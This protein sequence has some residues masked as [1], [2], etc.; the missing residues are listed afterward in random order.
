M[1]LKDNEQ[2]VGRPGLAGT[3]TRSLLSLLDPEE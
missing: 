1:Y 2:T 3:I